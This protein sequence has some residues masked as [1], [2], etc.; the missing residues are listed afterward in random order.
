VSD[1]LERVLTSYTGVNRLEVAQ[2]RRFPRNAMGKVMKRDMWTRL[3]RGSS[4]FI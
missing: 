4:Y 2:V 3:L 1:S